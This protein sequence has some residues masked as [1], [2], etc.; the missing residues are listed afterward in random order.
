MPLTK[1][2]KMAASK[3]KARMKKKQTETDSQRSARL[4]KA[5]TSRKKSREIEDEE[6]THG[7]RAERLRVAAK[8]KAELRLKKKTNNCH[9]L[10]EG[11][12]ESQAAADKNQD[13]AIEEEGGDVSDE[14]A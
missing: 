8:Q 11:H 2:E 7:Q 3:R 6:E 1:K 10:L 4:F 12:P 9:S 13:A 14:C 5:R